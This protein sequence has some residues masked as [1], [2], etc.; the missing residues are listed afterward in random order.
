MN[1]FCVFGVSVFVVPVV[2]TENADGHCWLFLNG[3][4]F[5][6]PVCTIYL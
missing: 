5:Y 6:L 3:F 2:I 4:A 1:I